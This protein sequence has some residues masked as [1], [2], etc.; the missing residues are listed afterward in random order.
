LK[1]KIIIPNSSK[2]FL[3]TQVD[4]RRHA[5]GPGV[6]VDVVCLKEGPVS[7]EGGVDEALVGPPLL[8]EARKAV[9]EGYEAIVIDCA[10]DP[11][12]R[13][14]RELVNIPVTSAGEAALLYALGLGDRISVVTVLENT[15]RVI[16]DRIRTYGF[17]GRVTSVRFANVPVL[18]L[19]HT[20]Q[21]AEAILREARKA[22]DEDDADVIV[23][24]CTGMSP[25]AAFLQQQLEVPVIDPAVAA[26]TLA[27]SLV[28]MRLSHSKK[29]YLTPPKKEIVG[30]Q[31]K[32]WDL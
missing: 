12:V 6:E 11:G 10:M 32:D 31:F 28:R 30:K 2:A 5:A 24:G 27:E 22:I 16:G 7:L 1:I 29:C 25:V 18:E 20:D 13:A 9:R 3:A 4:E 21:A 8:V 14:V 26:L 23:L 19:E 15:A 17:Q